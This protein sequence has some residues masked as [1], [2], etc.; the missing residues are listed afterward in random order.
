MFLA[1]VHDG[2][3][4]GVS[5]GWSGNAAVAAGLLGLWALYNIVGVFG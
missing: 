1:I 5:W 4:G 3:S 2:F